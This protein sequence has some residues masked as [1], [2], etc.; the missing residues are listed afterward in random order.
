MHPQE[1]ANQQ[2]LQ[3][4][5]SAYWTQHADQISWFKK[6][7]TTLKTFTKK[8]PSGNSHPS[9]QWFP[10]GELNTCYNCLDRH[11]VER[12]NGDQPAIFYH[13][14]VAGIKETYTYS[15]LLD[16]VQALASVLKSKGVGRGDTVVIYIPMIPQALIACLAAARIGAIHAV[17]FGGFGANALAQR[18]DSA[19]PKVLFTSSCGLESTTKIVD[20]QPFVR[21]A[22]SKAKVKVDTVLVWDREKHRW[23]GGIDAGRGEVDWRGA[24]EEAK[25]RGKKV[26]CVSLRSNE[27]LYI[28]YTSGT[29]G[30][31]KGVLRQNGGHAVGVL[32]SARAS[33]AIR[34][35]GDVVL[36]VSDI[37]MNLRA[38]LFT[39]GD[40]ADVQ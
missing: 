24:V 31:P 14:E 8:L 13:S 23:P 2:S 32:L 1:E 22:L 6:P 26:E 12:G 4:D 19:Q 36:G 17:V 33:A 16:E 37:G 30:A 27:G 3:P 38:G 11:I 21:G 35:P 9:W 34:G 40:F 18:I 10:D 7:S 28:I 25:R 5:R 15:R 29:T 39:D 20:Y